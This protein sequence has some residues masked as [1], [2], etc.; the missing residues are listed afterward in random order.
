M[1][2][3]ADGRPG[4]LHTLPF[5]GIYAHNF[6][7]KTHKADKSQELRNYGHVEKTR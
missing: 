6:A 5:P 4:Y 1:R 2:I 7:D 3:C